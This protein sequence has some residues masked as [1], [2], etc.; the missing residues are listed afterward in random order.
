MN[1]FGLHFPTAT[2]KG[3][4]FHFTQAIWRNITEKG[5]KKQYQNSTAIKKWLN[6]FKALALIPMNLVPQAWNFLLNTKPLE[7]FSKISDFINY[8]YYTWI[9]GKYPLAVWSHFETIDSPR[10]NNHVEGFNFALKACIVKEKPNIYTVISHLQQMET[11]ISSIRYILSH[12]SAAAK[13]RP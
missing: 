11:I 3:C 8:F 4:Y 9:K 5:L 12:E 10:T 7:E 1:A 2:I 6:Q 13:P